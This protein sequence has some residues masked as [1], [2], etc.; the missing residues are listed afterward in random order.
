LRV[1]PT[2]VKDTKEYGKTLTA[3]NQ[4]FVSYLSDYQGIYQSKTKSS[5]DKAIKYSQGILI[6]NNRNIEQIC[7]SLKDSDYYQMQH[8]ISDSPWKSQN[9][10]DLAAS[11]VSRALPARKLTGLL[12]DESGQ[13][14]KGSQSVGVGWQYCGNVGKTANSQVSVIGCLSNG[15][16]SSVVDARLYL[17]KEWCDD[18]DRCKKAGIPIEHRQFKTKLE[19]AYQIIEHQHNNGIKFDFVG[20]DGLY[21]NDTD[22][23]NKIDSLG[24]IYMLDIHA[25]Q[26][27]Y[28]DKPELKTPQRKGVKGRKPTLPKP[29]TPTINVLNYFKGLPTSQWQKV[30]V[31]NTAK[32]TLS[33]FYHAR[34]VHIW[35]KTANRIEKRLLLIRK[36]QTKTG[37]ELKFSFSNANLDQYTLK[38]LAYMQA[39]RF[40]IEHSI[41]ECKQVLGMSQ[42]QTRKFLA[43]QHQMALIIMM[44]CFMLKEKLFCFKDL[45]LLSAHDLR[46]WLC[47]QF[48]KE[49]TQ[50]DVL[51]MIY[52]RHLRRQKDLNRSYNEFNL[53]LSK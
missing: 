27:I 20:A 53:N 14:K 22:L 21:G 49:L 35:N 11:Q 4:R 46:D 17:S 52:Q 1:C 48:H 40:F 9:A 29:T 39:Q 8:F 10:M 50:D 47:F 41:K 24:Y 45:P 2:Q 36:I 12:V 18:D 3:A 51:F 15:D 26:T 31:R 43:W 23:A 19:L 37:V 30:N 33:A 13:V 42:F 16:F 28:L 44:L 6:S 34:K 5:F 7:D 32:G 25:D 38:G